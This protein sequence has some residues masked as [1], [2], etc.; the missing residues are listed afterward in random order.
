MKRTALICLAL[1]CFVQM[2]LAKTQA[3]GTARSR[4]S[5]NDGWRFDRFGPLPD[6][7][8]RAEPEGLA[9][10]EFED[11][12]WREL[13]LPHD[14]GIEG[15]FRQDLP[16][17]TGKLPW[18]GIGW[19]R[20][21]FSCDASDRGKRFFVDFDGAMSDAT[22]YVNGKQVG[23]WPYGYASFRVEITDHVAFERENVLAVRL[24]NKP[25]S[26]R[27]YPGGG[28]Y[29]NVWLVKTNP[30]HVAHRG[31][32]ITT[33]EV[34]PRRAAVEIAVEID[35][36]STT[37]E[38]LQIQTEI[39]SLGVAAARAPKKVG[40]SKP[41]SLKTDASGSASL[42][43]QVTVSRPKLWSPDSPSLYCA[44]TSVLRGKH[45]VDEVETIFGIR[46]IE[47]DATKGFWL[48]GEVT[49]F[50]G[51]CLHHDL[52]PLGAAVNTRALERQIELLQ[53]MGCN[54]IRTS[55]NPPAP[56]LLDL[57][58]RMGMLVQV[59]AFDCWAKGK[60]DN[61]YSRFFWKWHERDLMSM[62]RRDRNHPSV[63]MWSTGNEI[64]EQG[65]EK[66]HRLSQ[67]L[68]DIVHRADPTRPV[69]AGC[70]NV[71]AGT[72]GFQKT[73]DLFGYN[74]KPWNYGKFLKQN[75]GIP[76]YGSETA[77]CISSRGEYFFPVGKDKS[78]GRGGPFQMS[79]YDLYAPKWAMRPD[80]EF[81]AQDRF[82][83]VLGEFVWTGFDY[84]GEP[85]PYNNDATNLLNTE[86]P[87]LREEMQKELE[88]LGKIRVPSRS[89]YFGILDLCGFKKDRF[90]LYQATWRPELPMAHI[91]PHW[92]WPERVD[93]VTPVHVYT[94]GDEAELFLNGKSL[95]KKKKE[96][97]QYRLEWEDVKYQPG[98]L[99]VVAYKNGKRWAEDAK[100]TTGPSAQIE[101]TADR[102]EITADGNDLSFVTV[103]ILSKEGLFVPRAKHLVRFVLDGPGEIIAV[104][105]GDATS[106]QPFQ[107][108][109]IAAY[110]GMC[111]V[112]IRSLAGPSGQV[113][114][115]AASEGLD[116]AS[117]VLQ[118]VV[119]K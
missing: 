81:E 112:V 16:G 13:D 46:S 102:T 33:P 6:G 20:K 42:T 12:A 93:K 24:D 35:N 40:A 96:K 69:T 86:D 66:G 106:H 65:G 84:L 44:K 3:E 30:V 54:A 9:A 78:G 95:G 26:S 28:I 18:A 82:P 67:Q 70:N 10:R 107:A 62:V 76:L 104:G 51:V 103:R 98:E 14:W 77:S 47:Y 59:E 79:S 22:V 31:V 38:Q 4:S 19:Y 118:T 23:R 110:N 108:R 119:G 32:S 80:V 99:R 29:R 117:L 83:Q 45:L 75:P 17:R 34:T 21:H 91:L 88:S 36:Q 48:N 90:Y 50:R 1:G 100:K 72:N 85:T 115:E 87:K 37:A 53:E 55:H 52:G 105:N 2:P 11:S 56:E 7:S 73:V 116:G 68:T 97:Y 58:D 8:Q 41:A 25:N 43:Q 5:W 15:P 89:S 94:S 27:W 49:R 71:N 61:D 111:L 109:Q 114:L 60:T 63:V 74:Y 64:R 39:H 92:S 57:C 113:V 101:L